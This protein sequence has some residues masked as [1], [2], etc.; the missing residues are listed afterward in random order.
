[1]LQIIII[2]IILTINNYYLY[3]SQKLKKYKKPGKA[4]TSFHKCKRKNIRFKTDTNNNNN[5]NNNMYIGTAEVIG[6]T[7]YSAAFIMSF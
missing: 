7:L 4:I 5:N 3:K 6:S 2:I 1:M